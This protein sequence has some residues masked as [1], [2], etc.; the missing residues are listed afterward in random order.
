MKKKKLSRKNFSKTYK[1][2]NRRAA[3]CSFNLL[4]KIIK[5]PVCTS[6]IFI[7]AY[8]LL[9]VSDKGSD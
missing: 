1:T 3:K 8:V 9:L 2:I 7:Y 5:A 6:A 4:I